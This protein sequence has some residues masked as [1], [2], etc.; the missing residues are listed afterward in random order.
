MRICVFAAEMR[1]ITCLHDQNKSGFFGEPAFIQANQ[2]NL[3]RIQKA[4]IGWK[5]SHFCFD[6]VNRLLIT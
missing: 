5:K 4:L 3:K 2:S 6:H 1:F